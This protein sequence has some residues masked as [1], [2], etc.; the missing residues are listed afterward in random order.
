MV[1]SSRMKSF[2]L[3]IFLGAFLLFQVQPLMAKYVLPWFGGGPGV[4]TTCML[5][6]QVTLLAGYA[7]AHGA[8]RYFSSRTHVVVHVALLLLALAFLPIVPGT[9][10]KPAP[11]AQPTWSIFLLLTVCLG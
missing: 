6:F 8:T 11:D 4:W 5:F 2:A 9:R 7:H 3:A 10:W 1:A